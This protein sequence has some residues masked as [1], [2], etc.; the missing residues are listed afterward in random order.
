MVEGL[1][2]MERYQAAEEEMERS[3]E[4][5]R[6]K[7]K[8]VLALVAIESASYAEIPNRMLVELCETFKQHLFVCEK[9]LRLYCV[10][11]IRFVSS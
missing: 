7:R 6:D 2:V 4:S 1:V 3:C 11:S 9:P 10:V 8:G 5:R